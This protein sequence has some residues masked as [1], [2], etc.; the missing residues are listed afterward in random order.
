MNNEI[1]MINVQNILPHPDNPRKEL[2]DLTELAASIRENGILQNL[3]VVPNELCTYTAVIGHRRLAAAKL[4]EI[5]EV[6]CIISDMDYK[7]QVSTM[8]LENMQR[9]DLTVYEQAQGFQMM[10]DLGETISGIVEKTGFSESTVRHRIKLTELDQ[11]LLAEKAAENINITDLIKIEEIKDPERK[12][13]LLK[14]IGTNDFNWKYNQ[15][16]NE[17]KAEKAKEYILENIKEYAK[18]KEEAT[19]TFKYKTYVSYASEDKIIEERIKQI[20]ESD[21]DLYYEVNNH[22]V[23]IY[24][25]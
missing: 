18:P 19:G 5:D 3:T 22:S 8:L 21:E 14:A 7:T 10:L 20:R 16:K 23:D 11:E 24:K 6:P 25:K 2:G 12:N 15:F 9:S 1:V 4:A 17:E 13:T